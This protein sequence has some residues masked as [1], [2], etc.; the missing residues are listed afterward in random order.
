MSNSTVCDICGDCLPNV[1]GLNRTVEIRMMCSDVKLDNGK[2]IDTATLVI[3]DLCGDCFV[4]V[5]SRQIE[6]FKYLIGKSE[7]KLIA[8]EFEKC[9]KKVKV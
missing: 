8:Q 7:P 6:T 4:N 5:V 1:S 2:M 9:G 3:P